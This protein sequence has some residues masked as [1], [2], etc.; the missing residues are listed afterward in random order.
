MPQVDILN[1]RVY[2]VIKVKTLPI[3]HQKHEEKNGE[4]ESNETGSGYERIQNT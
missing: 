2:I 3:K 4:I 1:I